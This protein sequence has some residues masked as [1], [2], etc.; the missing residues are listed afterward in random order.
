MI[1]QDLL[2]TAFSQRTS[3]Y[4]DERKRC[5]TEFS[6]EAVHD[7]RVAARR[8]LAL[9]KI[10]R[11]IAPDLRLQKLNRSIKDELG[12]FNELRDTQ[13]MLVEISESI[14]SLPALAAL[15]TFLLKREKRLLKTARQQVRNFKA[16]AV[17]ARLEKLRASLTDLSAS[18]DL[19]ARL[20]DSA[21]DAFQTVTRRY[22]AIDPAAP[23]SI[24]RVRVAF[25]KFRYSI[26]L[27]C[28]LVPNFP[29]QNMEDMHI[30]QSLM[31]NIQ[32]AEV[33]LHSLQSFADTHKNFDPL[34]VRAFYQQ[35]HKEALSAYLE[36]MGQLYRFW[37]RAPDQFFPWEIKQ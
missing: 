33:F 34:P 11:D 26:E 6:E 5:K 16:R 14:E 1:D 25:K 12:S 23:A 17:S 8:L 32:D 3:Q 29:Q 19:P 30:Y 15:Q 7:L 24:H 4:L 36:E 18:P 21:D 2:L 10:L 31:G 20:L 27:V 13:V 37:R 35:R 22:T 9:L 28:P